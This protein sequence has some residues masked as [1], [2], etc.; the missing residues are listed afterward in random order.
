MAHL[1]RFEK[2]DLT[3]VMR[4]VEKTLGENYDPNLYITFFNLWPEGFIVAVQ[5][6]KVIGFALGALT[7]PKEARLLMLSVQK[8]HRGTGLGLLLWKWF[9]K[10][11]LM[12]GAAKITL[13]VR[14]TNKRAIRFYQRQGFTIT[15]IISNYYSTGESAYTMVKKLSDTP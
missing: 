12:K 10:A 8:Q 7:E 9:R 5:N 1:R 3:A 15:G 11:A 6:G 13:E 2:K 14:I 4:I